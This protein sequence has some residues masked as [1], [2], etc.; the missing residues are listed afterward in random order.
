MAALWLGCFIRQL[1]GRAILPVFDP[2]FEE[3]MGPII[4]RAGDQPEEAH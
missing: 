4:Q 2:E 3:T 1:R